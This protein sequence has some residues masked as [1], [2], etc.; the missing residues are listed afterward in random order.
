ML[1]INIGV[2]GEWWYRFV[3]VS[4]RKRPGNVGVVSTTKSCPS[5]YS[6]K[7]AQIQ[8]FF[9]RVANKRRFGRSFDLDCSLKYFD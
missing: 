5:S 4:G 9:D 7:W 6:R 3:V 1:S 2:L 8:E